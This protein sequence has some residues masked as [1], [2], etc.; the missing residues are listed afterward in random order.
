MIVFELD[1]FW[2]AEV[3]PDKEEVVANL[4]VVRLGVELVE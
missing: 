3:D 1:G 4:V 2:D